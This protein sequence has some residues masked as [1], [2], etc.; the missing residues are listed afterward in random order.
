MKIA[1]L[2]TLDDRRK[3]FS[4]SLWSN[5]SDIDIA[6]RKTHSKRF[7]ETIVE[8]RLLTRRELIGWIKENDT[9]RFKNLKKIKN[10]RQYC[11]NID[12]DTKEKAELIV[13][14]NNRL[15]SWNSLNNK[16]AYKF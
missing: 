3:L 12:K 13:Y 8:I 5:P 16:P 2:L 14:A 1:S 7:A 11:S 9:K 15:R 6:R 10:A 4:H